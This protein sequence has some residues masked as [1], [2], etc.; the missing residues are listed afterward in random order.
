MKNPELLDK[1]AKGK[2]LI[3]MKVMGMSMMK[4]VVTEKGGYASQQGQRKDFSG[5]ELKEQQA[6]ATPFPELTMVSKAGLVLDG[7]ES[8]NGSE[9]YV[10]KDGNST[11]YFDVN[12][13]YKL[14][15]VNEMKGED[16]QKASQTVNFSDYTDVKGIKVPY[17]MTMSV[18]IDIELNTTDV[19]F[20]EGVKDTDFQ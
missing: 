6:D 20:N 11:M 4:Q 10:I 3:E 17:K 19:K 9:A 14:G 16:G 12:S 8:Y 2:K 1:K 7:I 13:G 5:D 15:E 18:G